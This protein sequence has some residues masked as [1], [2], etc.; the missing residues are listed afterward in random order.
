M[1]SRLVVLYS[2]ENDQFGTVCNVMFEMLEWGG[3]S[4]GLTA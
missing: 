1:L 4:V 2:Y 3:G